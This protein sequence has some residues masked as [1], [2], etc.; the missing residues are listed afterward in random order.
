MWEVQQQKEQAS[1]IAH[2]WF[3]MFSTNHSDSTLEWGKNHPHHPRN[4]QLTNT[5][6]MT[7]IRKNVQP[8]PSSSRCSRMLATSSISLGAF[9]SCEKMPLYPS[10]ISCAP[11][12]KRVLKHGRE[13]SDQFDRTQPLG[14]PS[15][16][17]RS[18]VF[19]D[20]FVPR[21][22]SISSNSSEIFLT[23]A[24]SRRHGAP[25]FYRPQ[26]WLL[27]K[28]HCPPQFSA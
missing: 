2:R 5:N 21:G 6:K 15:S 26:W 9:R 7:Y 23:S 4:N 8:T 19:V 1:G 22:N 20:F 18:R 11:S 24:I 12:R 13:V 16:W 27:S 3:H 25:F 28:P 17:C 10:T 14:C